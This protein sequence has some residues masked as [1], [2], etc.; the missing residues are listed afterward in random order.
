MVVHTAKDVDIV[1]L[2]IH[3][4]IYTCYLFQFHHLISVQLKQAR[5]NALEIN[6]DH[7]PLVFKPF[8]P[9]SLINVVLVS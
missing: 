7:L 4:A 1:F 2:T 9:T 5:E 8:P 6:N 3:C